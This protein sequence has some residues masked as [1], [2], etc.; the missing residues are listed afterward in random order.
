ML[1]YDFLVSETRLFASSQDS[2]DAAISDAKC[3]EGSKAFRQIQ[4]SL[5]DQKIIG[6]TYSDSHASLVFENDRA[7]NISL[8][9]SGVSVAIGPLIPNNDSRHTLRLKYARTGDVQTW[10]RER[11]L[12]ACIGFRVTRL[13]RSGPAW[14]IYF[15][16]RPILFVCSHAGRWANGKSANLLTWGDSD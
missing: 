9:S 4:M 12:S 14:F 2:V 1:D 5:T 7:I 3:F 16:G 15:E 11:D 6:I 13:W 8:M 10:Q